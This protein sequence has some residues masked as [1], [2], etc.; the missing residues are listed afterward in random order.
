VKR[1]LIALTAMALPLLS[2]AQ[3]PRLVPD[4]SQRQID[5]IYSFTGAELLL[6]GAILYPD[7]QAPTKRPEIAVVIKGPS[8]PV[9]VREKQ[10]IAG[11]WINAASSSYRSVP[12]FYALASSRPINDI[13]DPRTAVIYELGID[14]LQLSPAGGDPAE[15]RRFEDGIVDLKRRGGYYSETAHGVEISEGVLYRAR[16]AIPARVPVGRYTAET[17]L[18]QNGR[19]VAAATRDIEIAKSGFE[20]FMAR[21]AER[22]AFIYG[23]V[24]VLLSLV[25][26]WMANWLFRRLDR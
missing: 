13:V 25:L 21:A 17:Y 9:L 4:V 5:I 26:G 12:S 19:V 7:G 11:M 15:A 14:N 8:E 6:F 23:I 24:A 10:K 22:H 1:A 20:A 18:I 16:I 2:A 3:A